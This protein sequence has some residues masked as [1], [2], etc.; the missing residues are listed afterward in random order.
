MFEWLPWVQGN[1][2]LAGFRRLSIVLICRG[3]SAPAAFRYITAMSDNQPSVSPEHVAPPGKTRTKWHPLLVR[4]L[5]FALDSAFKVEQEVSVGKL[6]LRVDILL[7]RREGGR[8]SEAR[9][10]DIAELL[11][12]LNRF[13]LIE[14]KAPTDALEPGDF[15]QLVGCC[16]LWHSQQSERYSRED[17]S[18]IVVAPAVNAAL[19]DELRLIGCEIGQHEPGI[20]RVTGLPFATWIVETDAMAERAQPILSLVSRDFL[21]DHRSI[22]ERFAAKGEAALANYRYMVQQVEQF[23]G[24]ED[25]AMQQAV[26]GTLKQFDEELFDRM[27][28][29]APAERRLRGLPPEER[30]RGLP[31]E[32]VLRALP[33]EFVSGLSEDE[34]ARLRELLKGQQGH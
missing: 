1:Y 13:T 10:R 6:P 33:K 14:F 27:I 12:L 17:I 21:N 4:M 24:E 8:L 26:T 3:L 30:L 34:L 31:P 29:E 16:Y 11:P 7:I 5:T 23:R 25:F 22:I 15:A 28:Q 32:D 9:A 2:I 19:R 20:W 18:L